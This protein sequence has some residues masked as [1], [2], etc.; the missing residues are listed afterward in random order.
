MARGFSSAP[1]SSADLVEASTG[2]LDRARMLVLGTSKNG[3]VRAAIAERQDCPFG[4]MVTLAHDHSPDVRCAVAAN[5]RAQ[6]SVLQYLAADRA[7]PVALALIG[8]PTL[9]SDILEELAYHRKS[10][11]R[12]A[13]SLRLDVGV[14]GAL[15]AHPEDEHTPE[16]AEHGTMALDVEWS[17]GSEAW[18][19]SVE[20]VPHFTVNAPEEASRAVEGHGPSIAWPATAGPAVA[21]SSVPE[22]IA[23]APHASPPPVAHVFGQSTAQDGVVATRT[24]PVRGFRAPES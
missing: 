14:P 9:P 22:V 7:V 17:L 23:G 1:G 15:E 6:R 12:A 21:A 5:P 16:L 20:A 13:A 18:S 10:E 19:R 2:N 4:L 24:A 11:V 8:N 3:L